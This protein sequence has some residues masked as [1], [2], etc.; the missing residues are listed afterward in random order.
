MDGQ[1]RGRV[2][3]DLAR[4]AEQFLK[5]RR[6]RTVGAGIPVSLW[7]LALELADRHGISRLPCSVSTLPL[8]EPDVQD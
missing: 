7:Q 6:T 4:G 8:I 1:F 5:W 2:P 3:E